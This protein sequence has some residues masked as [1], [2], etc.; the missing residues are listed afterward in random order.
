MTTACAP[1]EEAS[2]ADVAEAPREWTGPAIRPDSVIALH[3]LSIRR[4]GDEY[5]VGRIDTGTFVALPDVGGEAL[6]LL[7]EGRTVGEAER[8]LERIVG[9]EVDVAQLVEALVSLELV[10]AIDGR[11]V[12][13]AEEEAPP[14][15]GHLSFIEARHVSWLFGRPAQA[16]L[17]LVVAAALLT[18]VLQ[19]SNIPRWRDWFW[20]ARPGLVGVGQLVLFFLFGASH[21]LFH[22]FAA[23]SRGCPARMSLGTRLVFLVLQTDVSAAWSLSKRERLRIF[24]A[25]MAWDLFAASVCVL[26]AAHA[27]LGPLAVAICRA[28][29]LG[30]ALALVDQAHVY[31]RTDL[32]FVLLDALGCKNLFGDA[33]A[34][35]K[36]RARPSSSDPLST[37]PEAEARK[38]KLY[39]WFMLVGSCLAVAAFVLVWIPIIVHTC[40][41]GVSEVRAGLA[42]GAPLPVLDGLFAVAVDVLLQ[43]LFVRTFVK[44]H[45]TWFRWLRREPSVG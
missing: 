13:T 17:G 23:R 27:P 43:V 1:G 42:V 11:P 9:E 25:G 29:A 35:L 33:V 8:A 36:H 2:D 18:A 16:L 3:E 32:Y 24:L 12:A 10:Q 41:L 6:R 28:I 26:V 15:G 14:R 21:E 40:V 30:L 39:A 38:V 22:L 5:I 19:P 34:Y 31:M 4:E 44:T 20:H 45:P 7:K 37:L